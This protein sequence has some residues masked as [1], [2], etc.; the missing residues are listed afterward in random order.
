MGGII[1]GRLPFEPYAW[2]TGM[3]H[4]GLSGD[5]NQLVSLTF[6]LILSNMAFRGILPKLLGVDPPRLPIE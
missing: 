3:S 1:C 2:V 6:I 5:D 4:R